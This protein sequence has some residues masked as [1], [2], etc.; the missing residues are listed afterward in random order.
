MGASA[1]VLVIQLFGVPIGTIVAFGTPVV[2]VLLLAVW[3]LR[4]RLGR[5]DGRQWRDEDQNHRR[6]D[7]LASQS[8]RAE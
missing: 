2:A 1:I 3:S 8:R 7:P 5:N 4:R 6:G